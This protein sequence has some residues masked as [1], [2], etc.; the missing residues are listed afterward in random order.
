MFPFNQGGGGFGG[1]GGGMGGMMGGMGFGSQGHP[2]LTYIPDTAEK[3]NIAPLALLKMMKHCRNGIPFEV[4][5]VMLGEFVDEYQIEIIDVFAMPQLQ[6]TVSVEAV[7]PA[8]Q[9][10]MF[11]ALKMVGRTEIVVGWYHS[12]PGYGCWLSAVDVQTQ[13][14]FE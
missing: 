13:K 7:D 3:I 2:E 8:Y 6:T 4:M 9:A 12:H 1:M 11:E 10:R 5:G 14:S